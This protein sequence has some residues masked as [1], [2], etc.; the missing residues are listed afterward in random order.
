MEKRKNVFFH[1]FQNERDEIVKEI[2]NLKMNKA[3][4]S[5]DIPTKLINVNSDISAD[6][7]FEN[8][9][10][11]YLSFCFPNI[12]KNA[13]ITPAHKK[14]QNLLKG[15][16]RPVSILSHI[17]KILERIMFKQMPEYFETNLSKYH[18]AF[19]KGLSAQHCLLAM[20][21]K[22]KS[23]NHDKK[24]IG[25]LLTDVLKAFDCL[26]HDLLIA[27]LNAYGFSLPVL[28]LIQRYLSNR[29]QR[30][31][32]DF[33]VQLKGGKFVWGTSRIN[34]RTSFIQHIFL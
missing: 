10:N 9:N 34:F 24:T 5:S 12:I 14:V 1:F 25:V 3:T 28:R 8:L 33:K 18:F 32:I 29:K 2:N 11:F 30:I 17:S 26:C 19:R 7:I 13:T 6:F 23:A 27:K 31:N 20:L 22:W 15:N 4:Q 16:Y 21:E